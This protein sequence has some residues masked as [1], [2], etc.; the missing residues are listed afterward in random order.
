MQADNHFFQATF[1]E[2]AVFSQSYV[3]GAFVKTKEVI[4]V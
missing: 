2:E 1:V 4:A 3:F